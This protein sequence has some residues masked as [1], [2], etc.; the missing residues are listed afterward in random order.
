MTPA[1]IRLL[2]SDVDGTL[3]TS[4]KVLTERALLAVRQLRDAGIIFAITSSRPPGG[5]ALYAQPLELTTP[6]AAFNGAYISTPAM[7]VTD[8]LSIDDDV[9][10][11]LL[12]LIEADGL[13]AWVY[14]G[15][16]WFVRDLNGPHVQRE[17]EVVQFQPQLVTTFNDVC[18]RVAKIVAISD[19]AN[20]IA[21]AA[22]AVREHFGDRVSATSSQSYCVDITNVQANKGAVVTYL[23][24]LYD[25]PASEIAT[26]GDAFNDVLMF[27]E[28][29][30]SI[31]MGNAVDDVKGSAT[32]VTTTNNDEGFA[33]AVQEFIL[34]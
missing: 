11:P 4:D 7:E 15:E 22:T 30:V 26:I 18:T 34:S 33:N 12:D 32:Y 27:A 14:Q 5:L 3:V 31:A 17:A 2:L 9:I 25:I 8:E 19:D 16:Q 6:I 10:T 24:N 21:T 29:G 13:S 20:V 23:S 28:S 1:G